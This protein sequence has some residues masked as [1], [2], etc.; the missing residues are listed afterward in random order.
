MRYLA[1][2]IFIFIALPSYAHSLTGEHAHIGG[3]VTHAV[4]TPPLAMT[5]LILAAILIVLTYQN[6]KTAPIR[7][8]EKNR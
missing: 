6:Q 5:A 3:F 8:V 7:S 2:L 4:P 1:A